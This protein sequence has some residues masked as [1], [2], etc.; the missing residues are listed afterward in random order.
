MKQKDYVI[1]LNTIL[2]GLVMLLPGLMKLFIIK[3]AAVTQML[4]NLGFPVPMFFAWVLILSEILFGLAILARWKLKY[5]VWPPI[6]ILVIAGLT[7]S[8]NWQS[9]GTSQWPGF[10]MHI[11][12]ASNYWVISKITSSR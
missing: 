8:I 5:T 9:I 2:L 10:L 6:I 3:P 4:T 7:T 12:L 1:T 11:A